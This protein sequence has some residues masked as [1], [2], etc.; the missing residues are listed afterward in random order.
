MEEPP[1]PLLPAALT[2]RLPV[3][4][5]CLPAALGDHRELLYMLLGFM[6]RHYLLAALQQGFWQGSGY[7]VGGFASQPMQ[8]SQAPMSW[9]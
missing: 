7:V 8:G 6:E 2:W 1:F 3:R 9:S 4:L 5:R